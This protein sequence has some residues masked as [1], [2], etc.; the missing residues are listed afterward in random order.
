M[1]A[2]NR[3]RYLLLCVFLCAAALI[4]NAS[5]AQSGDTQNTPPAPKLAPKL[6]EE[7]YKNIQALKGIPADQ[8]IPSMQFISTSLGVDCEYCHVHGSMEKDDKKPKLAA[9]KMILMML[10]IN[11]NHFDG[12]REVT[13]NTCHRG[14]IAPQPTP[15]I[16]DE[17]LLA[18][19]ND[20]SLVSAAKPPLPGAQQ[21]LEKYIAASGG[22]A[23]LEKINTRIQKGNLIISYKKEAT[24]DILSKYP[25]K[26][27][28]TVHRASGDSVTG[29]NGEI[30]WLSVPGR[31]HVMSAEEREGARIDADVRFPL[32]I[33]PLYKEFHV[34]PG[35]KIS[36]HATYRV[37]AQNDRQPPLHL[38]FDQQS[39]LLLRLIRYVES[40]LG[41][42][43]TQIDYDDY[44]LA[45]G[46]QV[47]FRLTV[48]NPGGR[49]TI[50]IDT[51]QQNVPVDDARFAPPPRPLS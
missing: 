17:F 37:T 38:F 49:F 30:G 24:V 45:S 19:G 46:I 9:R 3:A 16:P 36:G 13:C 2:K 21:I 5:L 7:Q 25:E 39:G 20:V 50:Q 14:A 44:R 11:K 12:E 41:R 15:L 48:A 6:A 22:A 4:V 8:L 47:P 26:R 51:L 28:S 1:L 29:F 31:V 23:A 32:H 33:L 42:N 34:A 27:I 35:E 18:K 10:A 40:P 43:P